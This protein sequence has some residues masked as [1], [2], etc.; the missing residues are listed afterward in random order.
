MRRFRGRGQDPAGVPKP[1]AGRDGANQI[2]VNVI[3][4][5]A[6][7]MC[8]AGPPS[9]AAETSLPGAERWWRMPQA[10]QLRSEM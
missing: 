10:F 1:E 5:E 8:A 2:L 7:E 3:R 4:R 6:W 9:S